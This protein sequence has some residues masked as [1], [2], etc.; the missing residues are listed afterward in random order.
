MSQYQNFADTPNSI[1]KEGEEITLIFTRNADGTGTVSW[2]IPPPANGCSADTQAY[3]GI[4]ITV[5]RKAANYISTSPKNGTLYTGDNTVDPD[6]HAGDKLDTALVVGSFYHDKSTTSLTLTDVDPNVF[7]YVSGYAVDNVGTYHRE[8][9]HAYSLPTGEAESEQ[10]LYNAYQDISI[11][12]K[13]SSKVTLNT[14]TCL[15]KTKTYQIHV[16]IDHVDHYLT[17]KGSEAQSYNDLI[18]AINNQ[19]KL[20]T[21]DSYK[22][23]LPPKANQFYLDKTGQKLY[24]WDGFTNTSEH[25]I[26]FDKD[27]STHPQGTYWVNPN[28]P[29]TIF[30]YETG[31][32]QVQPFVSLDHDPTIPE[33]GELWFNGSSVY[34]WDGDHWIKLCLYIQ[35]RNPSLSPILDCNTYWYDNTDGLLYKWDAGNDKF[36]EVL[37]I[38][39]QKDPNTLSVGDFWLNETD[40]KMYRFSAG[41]WNLLTNVRYDKPNSSGTISNPAAGIYWLN[42]DNQKFYKRDNTNTFW[43]EVEYTMYPTDPMDRASNDLWWN[44]SPSVDS[45]FVWDI[46]NSQWLLVENFIQETTDPSL[47]PNLPACVVWYNPKD[48]SLKYILKNSCS[49]K[50]FIDF[51][52]DPTHP[53]I[54]TVWYDTLHKVYNVWNGTDWDVIHP[55]ISTFDPFVLD[56][57]Y[58][59]YDTVNQQL[60]RWNG[61]GWTVVPFSEHPLTPNV[62]TLWYNTA[63][64]E[65]FQWDG[66][67]WVVAAPIV[68]VSLRYQIDNLDPNVNGRAYLMFLF[69]EAGCGHIFEVIADAEGVFAK[70]CQAVMY[71]EP[72]VGGNGPA[73]GPMYK[74]LGVGTDGTPDERRA[75]QAKIRTMLGS[76][77]VQVELTKDEMNVAIDNALMQFRRYSSYGYTRNMFFLDAKPNQQ[78]YIL[79]NNCVGFNKINSIRALYRMQAGWIRTGLAGNEL[80]GVAALQQLYT[81]GTFDMLSFSMMSMYMK[82]LEQ[83]FASRIMHQ[84]VESSRELRLFQRIVLPER[85]LVDATVERTEQDL[86]TNRASA[87]WIQSYALAESKRILAQVRGKYLNLPGPNGSTNL[88]AQDLASQAEAEKTILM[89]ELNDPAMGNLEDVGLAAHF[90]IG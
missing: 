26:F 16:K 51:I 67:R 17:I 58:F 27:P 56:T 38:I 42:P 15:D 35:T 86:F 11:M 44:Q 23:P 25:V 54:G 4:V 50:G 65:L 40:S 24:L 75:L 47:P 64:N 41:V 8:G 2:N 63:S 46:V 20:I 5:D 49:D 60:K 9:V 57:N 79:S 34:E 90:V 18:R 61:T 1:I 53:P 85:I 89:E 29:N 37:A 81:V 36:D 71:H 10:A 45:L 14:L 69:N 48:G 83:V 12:S 77:G 6:M 3:D 59:W 66:V 31:G 80:F 21:G 55:I 43:T 88:N 82:E 68:S 87:L 76:I 62:G 72:L 33:C 74:Q 70:V 30:M 19:F 28:E 32:W 7:Y 22:S 13:D 78:T 52:F 73:S 39:S 84:W